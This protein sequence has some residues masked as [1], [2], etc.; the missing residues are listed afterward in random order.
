MGVTVHVTPAQVRAMATRLRRL[1]TAFENLEGHTEAYAP[2]AVSGD[3][4]VE[5][6]LLEFGRN[7]SSKRDEMAEQMDG[8]AGLALD[9]AK[10]YEGNERGMQ[11]GFEG[12][13]AGW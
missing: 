5:T 2:V 8:L 1:K 13:G 6:Q 12:G 10:A 9:A 3:S 4:R 11:R 7:W